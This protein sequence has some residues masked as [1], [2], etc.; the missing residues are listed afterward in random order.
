MKGVQ[1]SFL[2]FYI[3][4]LFPFLIIL[5]K[6]RLG[7]FIVPVILNIVFSPKS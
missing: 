1:L 3:I 5:E 2:I 6:W 4:L 7:K